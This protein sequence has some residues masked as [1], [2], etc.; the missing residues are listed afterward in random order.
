MTRRQMRMTKS[1]LKQTIA[2]LSVVVPLAGTLGA[3]W[4]LWQRLV[5]WNDIAILA[6]MYFSARSVSRSA[7]TA[8]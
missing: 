6:G 2:V 3:I 5:N 8:C 7:I 4:L 1:R